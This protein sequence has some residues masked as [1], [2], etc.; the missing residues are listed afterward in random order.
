MLEFF[1][2]KQYNDTYTGQESRRYQTI[3]KYLYRLD[4]SGIKEFE[5]VILNTG[6]QVQ[7]YEE[8]LKKLLIIKER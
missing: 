2:K 6:K 3:R 1:D 4:F 8:Y 7:S 5:A